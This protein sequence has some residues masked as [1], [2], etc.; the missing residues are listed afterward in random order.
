MPPKPR[1]IK[2]KSKLRSRKTTLRCPECNAIV[3]KVKGRNSYYCPNHGFVKPSSYNPEQYRKN[4]RI[5]FR[6]LLKAVGL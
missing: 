2:S 3:K 4:A 6:K 1:R 5:D